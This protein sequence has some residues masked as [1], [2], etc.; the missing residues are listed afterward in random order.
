MIYNV[1]RQVI[2]LECSPQF[3]D[4]VQFE[5][6]ASGKDPKSAKEKLQGKLDGVDRGGISKKLDVNK[7]YFSYVYIQASGLY[8]AALVSLLKHKEGTPLDYIVR[9]F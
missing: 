3:S 4:A 8:E 7:K 6:I 2:C 5:E 9:S 1:K